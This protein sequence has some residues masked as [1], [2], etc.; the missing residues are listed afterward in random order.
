MHIHHEVTGSGP[1]VLLTH[2][3]AASSHMFASTVA[4]LSTDHTVVVW[5][6]RGHGRSDSPGD[7]AAYSVRTSL[8]AMLAILDDIGAERAVLVGHSLGGYLSLELAITHPERVAALVLVDTGPGFRSDG[9]RDEWNAMADRYAQ[10][11]DDRGLDGMPGSDELTASVH[12][13]PEGLALAA[14]GVLRQSDGHVLEALPTI[15]VP[16]L[17]VVGERD[18]PFLIGSRYMAGK[19]PGA[20]LAVIAAAGHAPPVTHPDAFNA[21]LRTFL[22]GLP[23]A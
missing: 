14:R 22:T 16:T 3:F 17:V 6:M 13:S 4:D 7:P 19:I 1:V 21:V 5:D 20:Q 23:V 15:G 8:D 18:E 2:G 9:G 12:R 11:L 10:D